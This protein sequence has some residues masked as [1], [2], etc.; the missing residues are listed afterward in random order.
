ML[1]S[2]NNAREYRYNEMF[3]FTGADKNSKI[4]LEF[5]LHNG[6]KLSVKLKKEINSE[7]MRSLNKIVKYVSIVLIPIGI[8]LL[9][10][11]L[12]IPDNTTQNAVVTVVAAVVGMIQK[13]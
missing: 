6:K 4:T 13:D 12:S 10:K 7:I 3:D 1:L 2:L 9:L 8:L 11:Q 5:L